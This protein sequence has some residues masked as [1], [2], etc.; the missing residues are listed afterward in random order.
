M[1]LRYLN[2]VATF[3]LIFVTVYLFFIG[4]EL[5]L[6]LVIALVFWY[7]IIGVAHGCQ[8]IPLYRWHLPRS[9]AL[10][11]AILGTALVLYAFF[12]L[13]AESIANV[14]TDAPL[15]QRKL[16]EVLDF[17]NKLFGSQLN[18]NEYLSTL[19]FKLM[20]STLAG[21]VSSI[22]SDFVLILV[23]VLFLLL[24]YQTFDKKLQTMCKSKE[25]YH[26]ANIIR[27][28]ITKDINSYLKIKTTINFIAGLL[29]YVTLI[30]FGIDYAAFWGIFIFFL[31]YIP[32]I[33]SISAVVFVLLAVSVQIT[34]LPLFILLATLLII[35]QFAVGNILEPKWMGTRLNLSPIVILLSLA[36]WGTIWGIP[37][38]FLC[39]PLMVIL[40]I[41]LA[42]FPTTAPVAVLL[43]AEGKIDS[44]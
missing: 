41:I 22:A 8:K 44:E 29:S 18:I 34:T 30:A 1:K 36:F 6:P 42:K 40:N 28:K 21:I 20:F 12:F 3:G 23:Y 17:I 31:H 32:F 37:G 11:I 33:G 10:S 43:S 39:I 19:N 38:M 7:I 16:Q 26:R 4:K 25:Q 15:Y 13:L 24:E 14:I 9:I 35:I 5:L 27:S 2:F